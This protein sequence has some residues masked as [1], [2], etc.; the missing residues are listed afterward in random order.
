MTDTT[1]IAPPATP[2]ASKR[3]RQP[4]SA[5]KPAPVNEF[6]GVTS[7]LCCAGCT[8]KRCVIST[9]NVCKH[10]YKTADNGCGPVTLRNRDKVRKMIKHQ[11]IDLTG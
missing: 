1:Q 8:E 5:A 11:I 7:T 6:A 2:R 3:R 9:T 4:A 10:P